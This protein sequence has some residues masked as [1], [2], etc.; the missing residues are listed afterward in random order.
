MHVIRLR[1]PWDRIRD[2]AVAERIEVPDCGPAAAEP[3]IA[4]QYRRRFHR[5]S[6]LQALT[7]VRLQISGWEGRLESITLNDVAVPIAGST[8]DAELTGL[9]QPHNELLLTIRSLPGEPARLSG[10]VRLAIQEPPE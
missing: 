3:G 10:E 4:C 9:L 1:R 2:G 7:R 8:V 5:P 6:G